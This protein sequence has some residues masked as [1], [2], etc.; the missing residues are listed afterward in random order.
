MAKSNMH[1]KFQPRG[2]RVMRADR[3]KNRHTHNSTLEPYWGEVNMTK[4]LQYLQGC[5]KLLYIIV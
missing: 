5:T 4:S 2:F 1:K 3:Q